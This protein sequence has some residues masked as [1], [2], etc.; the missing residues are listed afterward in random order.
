MILAA[1]LAKN[2]GMTAVQDERGRAVLR[3]LDQDEIFLRELRMTRAKAIKFASYWHITGSEI[4]A[5]LKSTGKTVTGYAKWMGI[6]YD[7]IFRWVNRGG[8]PA[9]ASQQKIRRALGIKPVP[10]VTLGKVFD[11]LREEQGYSKSQFAKA[12][13]A[14]LSTVKYWIQENRFPEQRFHP[15]VVAVLKLTKDEA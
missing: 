3:S 12:I 4:S 10:E 1:Y 11:L 5:H 13:G 2:G 7:T 6:P 9:T 8:N 14:S 15:A